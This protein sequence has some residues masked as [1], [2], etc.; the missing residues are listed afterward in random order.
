MNCSTARLPS[1]EFTRETLIIVSIYSL[2]FVIALFGNLSVFMIL[3]RHQN[4]KRRRIHSLLL[5]N[6]I[7][8]L[9]VTLV[10]IPKEV[11]HNLTIAWNGGDTL[12]RLCKFFDVFGVSLS[13]NI[14]IC[15]SLDR[16]Y[17][18]LFP[19]LFDQRQ[20]AR[21]ADDRGRVDGRLL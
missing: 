17:S 1:L 16:F 6:T 14:L 7:A 8:H 12:C 20:E 13:A 3:L 15:L 5:H 21:A 19:A 4:S 10:Y 9:L 18:I 11:I 2:V